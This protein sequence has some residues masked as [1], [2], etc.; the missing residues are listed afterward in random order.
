MAAHRA[1]AKHYDLKPG[2]KILDVGCGKAFLLY[3]FTRA[4]PGVEI[5]GIDISAYG[6]ANSKEE[7]RPFLREGS[8]AKLPYPDQSFDFVYSINT[9]HNLK[10]DQLKASIQE[11][12]RVG[13]H[14]KMDLCRILP[15]RAGE[16]EPVILA[17]Y[18]YEL[19]YARRVGLA[20]PGMGLHRRLRL[21]FLRI[22][23]R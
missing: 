1:I 11:V 3:E 5:A 7:A 16:G 22:K 15:Q 10:V 13:G 6:I 21:H 14:R 17:T 8:C 18:L 9:F 20:I 19:F 23:M 2:D 4:V 12:E